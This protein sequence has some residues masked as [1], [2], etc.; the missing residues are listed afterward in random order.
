M[1]GES[2]WLVFFGIRSNVS[3]TSL[4]QDIFLISIR[5]R[6]CERIVYYLSCFKFFI[7]SS[8]L[9]IVYFFPLKLKRCEGGERR[10]CCHP[11]KK[12]NWLSTN[13]KL[14]EHCC[15]HQ[16][17]LIPPLLLM[18]PLPSMMGNP[19]QFANWEMRETV[20]EVIN[21]ANG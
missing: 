20:K 15:H 3:S 6:Q 4:S 1:H 18:F 9:Q 13:G 7:F 17:L 2:K 16:P 8:I 12:K 10:H 5:S 14:F 21:G 19:S 11:K